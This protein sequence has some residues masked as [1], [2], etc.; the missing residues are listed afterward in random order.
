M[1]NRGLLKIR[2]IIGFVF[3]IILLSYTIFVSWNYIKGPTLVV[4]F[5][6]DS[7]STTSPTVTILGNAMHISNLS[8]N[9]KTI[10]TD[11]KGN[12][13]ETLLLSPGTS[14]IKIYAKDRYGREVIKLIRLERQSGYIN[15]QASTSPSN[16]SSTILE[17]P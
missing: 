1:Q 8:L 2:F 16:A 10:F 17:T 11:E 9:D 14:I 3:L 12:F 5:P 13:K 4:M 6:K 15:P 7:Y